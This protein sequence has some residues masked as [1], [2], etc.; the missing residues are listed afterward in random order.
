MRAQGGGAGFLDPSGCIG[1]PFESRPCITMLTVPPKSAY[2]NVVRK[3]D[4][5]NS[6]NYQISRCTFILEAACRVS[7]VQASMRGQ[8]EIEEGM[9]H[10]TALLRGKNLVKDSD[11]SG[12]CTRYAVREIGRNA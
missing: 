8:F 4:N 7:F 9:S 11:R 3:H 2:L 6:K 10:D 12:L 1:S 5:V